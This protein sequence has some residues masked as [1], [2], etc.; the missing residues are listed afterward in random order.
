MLPVGDK[1]VPEMPD[2]MAAVGY[3]CMTDQGLGDGLLYSGRDRG[4]EVE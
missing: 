2:C 4:P 1:D 3:C